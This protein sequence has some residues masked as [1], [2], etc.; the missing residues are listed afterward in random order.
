[1]LEVINLK[2]SYNTR[3]ALRGLNFKIKKGEIYGLLGPNGAGKTTTIKILAGLISINSGKIIVNGESY[4][5]ENSKIKQLISYVPDEPFLY[6]K[7]TGEEHLQFYADLYKIP[8]KGRKKKLDFYF[9][10][11]EFESYRFELVENYSAGTRQKLLISQALFVEPK[12]LLLDEPLAS[13]DPLVGKKFKEL[14]K[15]TK[16]RGTVVIFATHILSL[17]QEVSDKIGIIV[18]GEI[19]AEGNLKDLLAHSAE[20]TLEDFYFKTVLKHDQPYQS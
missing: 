20:K 7:L 14:L 5:W 3:P 4:N 2:K 16:K 13:I 1:M 11:L 19:I 8:D 10:Y 12:I 17:A 6:P 15:E 18:N 9:K